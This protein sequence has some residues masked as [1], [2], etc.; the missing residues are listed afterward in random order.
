MSWFLTAVG[1]VVVAGVVG[2]VTNSGAAGAAVMGVVF[3]VLMGRKFRDA[4]RQA[5]ARDA[6]RRGEHRTPPAV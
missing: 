1:L 6:A 2:T 5:M 4:H 3:V